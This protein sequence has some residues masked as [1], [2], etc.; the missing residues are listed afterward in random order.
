MTPIGNISFINQ[1]AILASTQASNELGKESFASMANLA[2]FAAKEKTI[3]KL[4]KVAQ[5]NEVQDE[6][7]ERADEEEGKKKKQNA[8]EDNSQDLDENKEEQS[9]SSSDHLLDLSI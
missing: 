4:E 5:S 9:L 8:K 3:E 7:K 1:N 6:I 2:E